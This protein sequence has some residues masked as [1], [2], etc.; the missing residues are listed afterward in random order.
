VAKPTRNTS[1]NV[2]CQGVA[3]LTPGWARMARTW[4]SIGETRRVR[5]SWNPWR[6]PLWFWVQW[7][8]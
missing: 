5:D 2:K 4:L 8:R 3:R 1:L 6:L 7:S